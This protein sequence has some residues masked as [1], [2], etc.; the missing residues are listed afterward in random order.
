MVS[1]AR[2][3]WY[4]RPSRVRTRIVT[5]NGSALYKI[6]FPAQLTLRDADGGVAGFRGSRMAGGFRA[7]AHAEERRVIGFLRPRAEFAVALFGEGGKLWAGDVP[8]GTTSS[9]RGSLGISLLGAYPSGS[10]RTY[11]LDI[12]FPLN[13]ERGGSRVEL[14]VSAFDR[15]RLLSVEPRDVSRFRTGAMPNSLM[16]W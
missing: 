12:A 10:K 13:P 1:N 9:I 11:R 8:Y 2:L 4:M 7:S 16:R 15:T 6:D 3:S 14:R 5:V